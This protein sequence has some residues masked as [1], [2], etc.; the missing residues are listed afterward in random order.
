MTK[1]ELL[2]QILQKL[3]KHRD[4]AAALLMLVE[5]ARGESLLEE[6]ISALKKAVDDIKGTQGKITMEQAVKTLE[7]IHDAELQER[8]LEDNEI[9]GILDQRNK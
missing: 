9:Q 4:G 3:R 6:L 2:I 8:N 5:N 1:K 7:Q